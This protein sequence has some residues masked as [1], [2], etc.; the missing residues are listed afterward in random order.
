MKKVLDFF[1]FE[2]PND[3]I[4]I[5][6]GIDLLCQCLDS[7]AQNIHEKAGKAFINRDAERITIMMDCVKRIDEMQIKLES[8]SAL[9]DLDDTIEIAVTEKRNTETNDRKIP[10]YADYIVDSTVPYSLMD[11]LTHKRPAAFSL[12]GTRIEAGDWKYIFVQTCETLATID[13]DIFNK[14]VSD[15]NMQGRKVAYFSK[16]PTG[17]RKAEIIKGTGIYVTTNLSA[18]SIRNIIQKMLRK[19]SIPLN[20]YKIYLKADYTA[21]HE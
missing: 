6:D 11:D 15:K 20:E 7:A 5:R 19:Y 16:D 3:V 2:F 10:N 12:R 18:N 13:K 4:D 14:F 17:M 1:K 21:L 9:L 8:Y